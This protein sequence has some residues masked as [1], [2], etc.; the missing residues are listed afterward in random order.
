MCPSLEL[1]N[2]TITAYSICQGIVPSIVGDL[3]DM[4][5]RRPVYLLVFLTYLSANTGLALQDSYPALLVL[6]M[7]QST[8]SSGKLSVMVV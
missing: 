3:A 6:R 2:L 8:G 1:M 7:F 4:I 5:G